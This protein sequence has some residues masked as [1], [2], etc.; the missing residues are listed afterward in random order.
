MAADWVKADWEYN[1]FYKIISIKVIDDELLF[2]TSWEYV[3]P[4]V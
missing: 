4:A 3:I 1:N 2:Y